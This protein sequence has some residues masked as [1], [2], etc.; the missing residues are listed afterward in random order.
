MNSIP[1][2]LPLDRGLSVALL[3]FGRRE[4]PGRE[5][6]ALDGPGR[7]MDLA[8][9]PCGKVPPVEQ[10]AGALVSRAAPE[11]LV[12]DEIVLG[13]MGPF[14]GDGRLG[15]PGLGRGGERNCGDETNQ[16]KP[17]HV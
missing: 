11:I 9:R 3:E 4:F 1:R 15:P 12:D 8:A 14:H 7:A 5:D 16:G 13:S 2:S 10:V 17:A 6:E